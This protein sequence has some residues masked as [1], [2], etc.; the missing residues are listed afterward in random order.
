MMV[1]YAH[2]LK[3]RDKAEWERLDDHSR[4]VAEAAARNAG[5][6]APQLAEAAGWL[7]DLGKAKPR[8]QARLSNDAIREP[9]SA[10]GAKYARETKGLYN[11]VVRD[12]LAHVI[13]GHHSGLPD[14]SGDG[15][16]RALLSRRL[17]ETALLPLPDGWVL[18][19]MGGIPALDGLTF[20][21]QPEKAP[22]WHRNF[23]LAFL[24]RMVF[25]ALVDADCSETAA[26][27]AEAKAKP[28]AS[29]AAPDLK[30]LK[31]ALDAALSAKGGEGSVNALRAE[32]LSHVRSQADLE[33][34]LFTLTVPTGGGKTLTSLAFALDHAIRHNLDRVIYVIPY[35][36]IVEQTAQVFREIFEKPFPGEEI[37]LEHHSAFDWDG[38]AKDKDEE[39]TR[40]LKEAAE[41]WDRPIIVT[42][43][44]QF[45]ESLHGARTSACRKLHRISGA[46]VVMDEAQ[47]LPRHLLLP[48][49][50]SLRELA[51]GYQTSV[52]FCTATQPAILKEDGFPYR[53]E[54]A[55]GLS[56]EGELAVR[57]LAPEPKK[58]YERLKRV[59]TE[60]AEGLD[61]AELCAR[62]SGPQGGLLIL[63]NRAH[64]R[65]I[66]ESLQKAKVSDLYHLT[67]NLTPRH[68]RAVL[69]KVREGL[70]PEVRRPVRLVA[71]S[72]VEAGVDVDFPVV[73]R[74]I[75]GLDSLAQ[76]AGRCNREGR[77]PE[78]GRLIVFEP[79]A[80]HRPPEA[81]KPL[82]AAAREIL[83]SPK[84]AADPLSLT[85][86]NDYFRQV[87]WNASHKM[88][89][90]ILQSI[91]EA[92]DK[93]LNFPFATVAQEYWLI[94]D[95]GVP[96]AIIGGEWGVPETEFEPLE[97]V[98]SA[99]AVA[100]KLQSHQV[101][102]PERARRAM[103]KAGLL[104]AFRPEDFGEQFLLME[105][106]QLYH[107]HTG[108]RWDDFGDLGAMIF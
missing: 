42:T 34:G 80:A 59:K 52:I 82:A 39:E 92:G 71:T 26:F 101:Q 4:R 8:F 49:L 19:P 84:Y 37:V 7:H 35:T 28:V 29:K 57:E 20:P 90:G 91:A 93:E 97:F 15:A 69:D 46:V 53:E 72:L 104:R 66:F 32:V 27:Y 48:S 1:L 68:R 17:L 102:I 105:A 77:M 103:F 99:G 24:A 21:R 44:V 76:A 30:A 40:A 108:L 64:A 45:L 60:Y 81:L 73:Y 12:I 33:K 13:A 106:P 107:P 6:F 5:R 58:L 16:G 41:R 36:S 38:A 100:R 63:N 88:G 70:K 10:E 78:G 89:Q 25:S 47:T 56:R 43:A 22:I 31:A 83:R 11:P 54:W 85:A 2:S 65:K 51:R 9:H 74:V 18:P 94:E 61:D 98:A 87:Y 79:E 67:T 55:E 75:A 86:L 95:G 50:A 62:L 14:G 3:G 23:H 96:V